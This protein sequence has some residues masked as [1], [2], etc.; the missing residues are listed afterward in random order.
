MFEKN[1]EKKKEK[2]NKKKLFKLCSKMTQ[3]QDN[4][5]LFCFA[6]Y[7]NWLHSAKNCTVLKKNSAKNCTL[8]HYFVIYAGI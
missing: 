2:E 8:Y 5:L 7:F 4:F 3:K 1:K 6:N